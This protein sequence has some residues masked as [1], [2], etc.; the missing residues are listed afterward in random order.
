FL[1]L[2]RNGGKHPVVYVDYVGATGPIGSVGLQ[3][4]LVAP[5]TLLNTLGRSIEC[6]L[7][8]LSLTRRLKGDSR[9]K[10]HHAVCGET[11]TRLFHRHVAGEAAIEVLVDGITDTALDLRAERVADFHVL[12]RDTQVHEKVTFLRVIDTEEFIPEGDANKVLAPDIPVL[13]LLPD[14]SIPLV[15]GGLLPSCRWPPQCGGLLVTSRDVVN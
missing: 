3:A 8:I 6:H 11:R 4:A 2:V 1:V 10:P 9:I 5:Q 12:T 13:R 14:L 15:S 7:R